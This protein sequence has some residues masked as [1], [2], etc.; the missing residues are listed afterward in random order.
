MRWINLF[1]AVQLLITGVL[2]WRVLALEQ[3]LEQSLE[4][5]AATVP[6][7]VSVPTHAQTSRSPGTERFPPETVLREIIREELRAAHL[8]LSGNQTPSMPLAEPTYS[9]AFEV[10]FSNVSAKV[11]SLISSGA[12]NDAE[13][14]RVQVEISQLH[15]RDRRAVLSQL[16]KAINAGTVKLTR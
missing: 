9:K 13:M 4:S 5:Q 15:P 11:A 12:I 14:E 3:S 2:V 16:A 8:S 7:R 1:A 6:I 10:Q